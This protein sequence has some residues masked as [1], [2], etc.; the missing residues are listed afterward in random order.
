MFGKRAFAFLSVLAVVIASDAAYA[1]LCCIKGDANRSFAVSQADIVPFVTGLL[2]PSA[3]TPEI[4]CAI[5]MDQNDEIDGRDLSGFVSA[6]LDPNSV[7]FDYGPPL[8]DAEAH[9]IALES[10]GPTGPLLVSGELYN[11]VDGDLD[12]IRANTPALVGQTHSPEWA[13]NQLLVK[14][15]PGQPNQNYACLNAYYR[16]TNVQSLGGGWLVLTFAGRSNV[17][18]LGQIYVALPE[19]EFADPN[20]FIGGENKWTVAD[21]GGGIFAWNVDDGFLDCFDGC[22]CHRVYDFETTS[23][24]QVT[25]V[26]YQEFGQPW[27]E[28]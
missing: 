19:V 6:L 18:A 8:P 9:Q 16:I 5:D 1:Q 10:L 24:G 15:V 20:G 4:R 25:L 7:L 28:F 26:N 14:L 21:Q 2:N 27:C 17:E 13:P 12:L 11:R 23:G 3:L 22:D